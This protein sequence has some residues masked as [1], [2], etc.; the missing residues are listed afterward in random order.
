MFKFLDLPINALRVGPVPQP[1]KR[2]DV[3]RLA[4]GSVVNSCRAPS[5]W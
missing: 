2:G 4:G 1:V 5:N 3:G